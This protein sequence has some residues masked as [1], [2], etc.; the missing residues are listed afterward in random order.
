VT[1]GS[2][3]FPVVV[4]VVVVDDFVAGALAIFVVS[5]GAGFVPSC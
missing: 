1:P 2:L 4:V 5:A 3:A